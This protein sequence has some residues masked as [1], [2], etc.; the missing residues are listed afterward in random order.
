METICPACGGTMETS[1]NEFP[2]N[3]YRAVKGVDHQV[4]TE[5]GE[6]AFTADQSTMFFNYRQALKQK[7]REAECACR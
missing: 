5:C 6:M 7:A 4:C 3:Q 2:F 1:T